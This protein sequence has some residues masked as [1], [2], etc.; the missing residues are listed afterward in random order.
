ML[1]QTNQLVNLQGKLQTDKM[2]LH[3]NWKFERLSSIR[4]LDLSTAPG[5]I[6][7]KP[8]L[9]KAMKTVLYNKRNLQPPTSH[10]NYYII[11]N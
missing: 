4:R 3:V 7:L 6:S 9:T 10:P 5:C 11:L 8:N 1:K 2:K